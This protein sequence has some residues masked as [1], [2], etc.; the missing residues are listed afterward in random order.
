[1][2]GVPYAPVRHKCPEENGG[3]AHLTILQN[4]TLQRAIVRTLT[5]DLR[6]FTAWDISYRLDVFVIRAVPVLSA[7]REMWL[8]TIPPPFAM[9]NWA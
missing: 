7:H 8:T 9:D 5:P 1:M 6:H 2:A 3:G 4:W